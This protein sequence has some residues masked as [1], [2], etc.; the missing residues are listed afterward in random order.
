M[1]A[2]NARRAAQQVELV[3]RQGDSQALAAA[4][5]SFGDEIARVHQEVEGLLKNGL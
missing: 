4:L 1:A 3:A 2:T 5:A